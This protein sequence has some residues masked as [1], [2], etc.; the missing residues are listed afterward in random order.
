LEQVFQAL[1]DVGLG[2]TINEDG[3]GRWSYVGEV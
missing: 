2:C 3:Q 1:H